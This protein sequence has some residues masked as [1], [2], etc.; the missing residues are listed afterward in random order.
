M[1]DVLGWDAC[2][3]RQLYDI[4]SRHASS[5]SGYIQKMILVDSS[6]FSQFDDTHSHVSCE[7]SDVEFDLVH[8]SPF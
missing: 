4:V 3:F 7:H 2:E 1:F 6:T 8:L 5:T